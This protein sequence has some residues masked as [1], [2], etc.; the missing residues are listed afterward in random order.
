MTQGAPAADA[1]HAE[2]HRIGANV[3]AH[4]AIVLALNLLM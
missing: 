4:A 1:H 3:H 2:M